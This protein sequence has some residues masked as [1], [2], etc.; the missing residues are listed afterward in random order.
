MDNYLRNFGFEI[1]YNTIIVEGDISNYIKYDTIAENMEKFPHLDTEAFILRIR[2]KKISS[3]LYDED[4]KLN[5]VDELGVFSELEFLMEVRKCSLTRGLFK[6][7]ING[8]L[9]HVNA[10]NIKLA[11][12]HLLTIDNLVS[13]CTELLN[14]LDNIIQLNDQLARVLDSAIHEYMYTADYITVCNGLSIEKYNRR[15]NEDCKRYN[16][17]P[18]YCQFVDNTKIDLGSLVGNDHDLVFNG[19]VHR[20]NFELTDDELLT[21]LSD[22]MVKNALN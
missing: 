18:F 21:V 12:E 4:Y 10:K 7:R 16:F 3:L 1:K 9:M 6:C 17:K 5:P 8:G 22:T 14:Y 2:P 11:V 20:L 15:F 19:K 13:N